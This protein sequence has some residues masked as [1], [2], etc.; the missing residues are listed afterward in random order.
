MGFVIRH[1]IIRN[2]LLC[3]VYALFAFLFSQ[4]WKW[5]RESDLPH[6]KID[7]LIYKNSIIAENNFA[8]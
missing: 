3:F 2:P 4:C 8:C 7:L 5:V 1:E 6:Y